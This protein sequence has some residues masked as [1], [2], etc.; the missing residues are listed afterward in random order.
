MKFGRRKYLDEFYKDCKEGKVD[1]MEWIK[2]DDEF[3]DF[4]GAVDIEYN[5]IYDMAILS[6][7]KKLLTLLDK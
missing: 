3:Y 7:T 6:F 2:S 4:V 5:R 1:E